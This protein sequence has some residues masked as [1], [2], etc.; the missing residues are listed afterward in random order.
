MDACAGGCVMAA[1]EPV[2]VACWSVML[3]GGLTLALETKVVDS[4]AGGAKSCRR[5]C[6]KQR[7]WWRDWWAGFQSCWW[8]REQWKV[9]LA[10]RASMTR[11]VDARAG[12]VVNFLGRRG[13]LPSSIVGEAWAVA[14]PL[15]CSLTLV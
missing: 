7:G 9:M 10:M 8:Q 5:L 6:W 14:D 12:D 15:S 3:A 2:I 13:R 11:V 4:H 1:T